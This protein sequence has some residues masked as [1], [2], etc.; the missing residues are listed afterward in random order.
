M[1]SIGSL[2]FNNKR[3]VYTNPGNKYRNTIVFH[4]PD[5]GESFASM[6]LNSNRKGETL[7][8]HM[9]TTYMPYRRKGI[10]GYL[11]A[12]IIKAAKEAGFKFVA[13]NSVN[14][15][16]TGGKPTSAYIMEKLGGV[17][18]SNENY[19]YTFNLSGNL[20]KGVHNTVRKNPR[21]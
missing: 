18:N 20:P 5:T 1:P 7:I 8:L 14:L 9:G 3:I 12:H 17:R 10:G 6:K 16:G 13:Q 15:E 11:R 19:H 2:T 21:V 4:D